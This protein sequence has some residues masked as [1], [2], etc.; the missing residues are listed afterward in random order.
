MKSKKELRANKFAKE[1]NLLYTPQVYQT[2]ICYI[3]E[4]QVQHLQAPK[5]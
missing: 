1:I 5:L 3:I 2:S 4:S